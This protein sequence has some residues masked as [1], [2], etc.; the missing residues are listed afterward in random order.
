MLEAK[1]M[2]KDWLLDLNKAMLSS[3]C[4]QKGKD[5]CFED[6][7]IA[8]GHMIKKKIIFGNSVWWVGNGGS[9]A[10]CSHLSQDML[11]KLGAKSIFLS[12]LS[13]LTCISNDFGYENVYQRPLQNFI[14]SDDLLVAISSSGNSENILKSAEIAIE[15]RS[16]LI[17]LSGMNEDNKLWNLKSD[18]SF[19]VPS[20]LYG[21]IEVAHEAILHAVIECLW[22]E[23]K[24]K[25]NE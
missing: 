10:I 1:N 15:K 14:Q 25:Q 22:L 9:A 5:I 19:F 23:S 6:G 8:A 7:L 3:N 18:L 11:N 20:N 13:L 2:S 24:E 4:R 17:T 12:D 21:I 16:S